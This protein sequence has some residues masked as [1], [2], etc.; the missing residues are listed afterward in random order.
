[1]KLEAD[2]MYYRADHPDG[3]IFGA[4]SPKPAASDGW[5]L[6]PAKIKPVERA[7]EC[8]TFEAFEALVQS[9]RK[10]HAMSKDSAVQ[11]RADLAAAQQENAQLRAVAGQ[12]HAELQ[13]M[14]GA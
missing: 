8:T 14:K 3:Y 9:E 10:A 6:G 5:V 12:L 13:A 1:M 4:G 11:M 2:T 7:F